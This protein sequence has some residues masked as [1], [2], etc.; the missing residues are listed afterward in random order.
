MHPRVFSQGEPLLI[1]DQ[2]KDDLGVRKFKPMWHGP[3]IVKCMLK[4]GSYELVDYEGNML[5]EPKNGMCPYKYYAWIFSSTFTC[6]VLVEIVVFIVLDLW[7]HVYLCFWHAL[8]GVDG[9]LYLP[10]IHIQS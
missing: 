2:D 9:W 6:L 7:W 4:K 5:S 3:Y 1:Y 10:R 8:I